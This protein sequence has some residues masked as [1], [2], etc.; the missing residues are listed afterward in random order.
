MSSFGLSIYLL[1]L[2]L[3]IIKVFLVISALLWPLLYRSPFSP[4]HPTPYQPAFL[5]QIEEQALSADITGEITSF[6]F[7]GWS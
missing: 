7:E 3:S 5:I 4:P 2:L 6:V 1:A